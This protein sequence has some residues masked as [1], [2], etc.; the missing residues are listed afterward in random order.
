MDENALISSIDHS[1]CLTAVHMMPFS[2]SVFTAAPTIH[3]C[4]CNSELSTL[5]QC[6]VFII[7]RL[8]ILH[9]NQSTR[10]YVHKEARETPGSTRAATRQQ[11]SPHS[12][13]P[14]RSSTTVQYA[15]VSTY[16]G[17]RMSSEVATQMGVQ[18]SDCVRDE[19]DS[20]HPSSS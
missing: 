15:R 10:G 9:T 4:S 11:Q 7:R 6:C 16:S 13:Q 17:M 14:P 8:N 5:D 19:F 2:T 1:L 18:L 12:P 3:Q 20:Q